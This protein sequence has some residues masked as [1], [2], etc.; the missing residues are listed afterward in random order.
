MTS[1]KF[2]FS[3]SYETIHEKAEKLTIINII[4]ELV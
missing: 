2:Y 1:T 4:S 3:F